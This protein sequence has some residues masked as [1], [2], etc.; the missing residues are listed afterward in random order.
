MSI[1]D[2]LSPSNR[3][4]TSSCFRHT[5]KGLLQ[6]AFLSPLVIYINEIVKRARGGHCAG[7]LQ[8]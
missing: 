1:V 2:L 8:G 7:L 3:I 4:R 6:L 5:L